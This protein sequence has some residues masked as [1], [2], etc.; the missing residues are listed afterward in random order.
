MDE[1]GGAVMIC[2][3][4]YGILL[5]EEQTDDA[6]IHLEFFLVG[7]TNRSSVRN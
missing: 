5:L 4:L 3:C 2:F 7:A 1:R 6:N